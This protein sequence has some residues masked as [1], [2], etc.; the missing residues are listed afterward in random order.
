MATEPNPIDQTR[1]AIAALTASI[2]QA[3]DEQSPG[4]RARVLANMEK[5]YMSLREAQVSHIG[6]METLSWTREF[7]VELK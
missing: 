7:L 4:V 3:L 5:M 1:L 2:V 6:A